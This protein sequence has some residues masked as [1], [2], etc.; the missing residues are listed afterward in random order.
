MMK[1]TSAGIPASQN[2]GA[3]LGAL[4]GAL[5]L[6]GVTSLRSS[7][8]QSSRARNW[9][10]QLVAESTGKEGKGIVPVSVVGGH[11]ARLRQRPLFI[12][13]KVQDIPATPR[14]TRNPRTTRRV[15][16]G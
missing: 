8:A 2:P 15:I 16:R 1:A 9:V 7:P 14:L 4:M 11:A 6:K 13:I 10:E 12:Y 5:A 3:Y